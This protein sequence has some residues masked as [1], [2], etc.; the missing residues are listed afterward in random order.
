VS[1]Q[2]QLF[3]GM[4]I[5]VIRTNIFNNGVISIVDSVIVVIKLPHR[6]GII[7]TF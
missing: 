1:L 6:A 2:I 4:D 3:S 7:Q 5:F